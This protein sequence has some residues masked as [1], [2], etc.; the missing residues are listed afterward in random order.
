MPCPLHTQ[1]ASI[2]AW[3]DEEHVK[4]NRVAIREKNSPEFAA[5]LKPVLAG[6]QLTPLRVSTCGR[7]CPAPTQTLQE[8]CY[9][10]ENV[11]VLPGSY[12]SRDIGGINPGR[13]R[14]RI[15]LVAAVEECTDAANRIKQFIQN[16]F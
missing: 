16:S 6:H 3:G 12:L 14:A 1:K 4:H 13:N 7:N 10:S 8:G 2:A 9:T 15:A 11:K 5:I